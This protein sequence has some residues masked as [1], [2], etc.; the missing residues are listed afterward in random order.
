MNNF[1]DIYKG[2]IAFILLAG[3][4]SCSVDQPEN[5][6]TDDSPLLL[7]IHANICGKELSR[8][9]TNPAG[10]FDEWSYTDFQVGDRMGF[11]S[12][13]GNYT[14]GNYGEAPFVNQ[15]L[16]YTGGTGG[17]N[18]RDPDD[19]QFSP[20]HMKG[21]EIFM[22]FPYNQDITTANG[23][24]LRTKVG[25]NKEPLD[26]ARCI[27]L[28][29]TDYLSIYSENTSSK[30]ALY[31]EFL[32]TFAELIIMR[33]KGFDNPPKI[34]GVNE[35]EIKVVLNTPITGLTVETNEAGEP[36]KCTPTFVWDQ[37]AIPGRLEAQTWDAWLG[38]NF[39][40]TEQ[41]TQGQNAW[42]VVVP[43]IG[44]QANVGAKRAG[45]RTVVEYIELYDNDGNLQRV[46][47]LRLS[48]SN[49]KY[50]DGGWRYPM[51]ISMEELV[52]TAN[53]C[54]IVPWK[55][56]VDLTDARVRGIN[57]VTEFNNWI[58]A[59]NSYLANPADDLYLNAL[60][61]YGDLYKNADGTNYWHFYV[62]S[63]L[64]LSSLY[65]NV[66]TPLIPQLKDILDGQSTNFSNGRFL[67]YNITGLKAPLVGVLTGENADVINFNFLHPDL[68][69]ENEETEPA[70]IVANSM[71]DGASVVNCTIRQGT[72]YHPGGPA[73]MIAGSI[74]STCLIK[75]CNV[76]GYL[77]SDSN[78]DALVGTA[79][80]G[81][82]TS[83]NNNSNNVTEN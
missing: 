10:T 18:F 29:S 54:A 49:S 36:W 69:F 80:G 8:A 44:C 4:T 78:F 73:G 35:W 60:F 7:S 82:Y 20:T 42:Y 27:D 52:P 62:L 16:I 24:T 26:T 39:Y 45:V 17:D 14:N 75:D 58:T 32:H 30:A 83:E 31:G 65:T 11:F 70:G 28:L 67:N 23:I 13:G 5:E 74:E 21:N 51:Q 41:D 40:L 59:Y 66:N 57:N 19:T 50:V 25:Q 38:G 47:S 12:S 71:A 48:N 81:S 1:F 2:L 9:V 77:I 76:S 37:E 56:D 55:P 61:Q 64:D 72:M 33:G 79:P 43:T 46:S 6:R 34:P 63:D 68:Q 22:Y 3:L 15:E 53:P